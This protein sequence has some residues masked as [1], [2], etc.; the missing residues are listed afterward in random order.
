MLSGMDQS[1]L[2]SRI[3]GITIP[4][5]RHD[6]RVCV[7]KRREETRGT[8]PSERGIR[9][10]T[11]LSGPF[12][13]DGDGVAVDSRRVASMSSFLRLSASCESR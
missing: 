10:D 9:V 2:K 6:P 11:A 5:S 7:R 12:P 8:W 3:P 4:V 13:G 1:P